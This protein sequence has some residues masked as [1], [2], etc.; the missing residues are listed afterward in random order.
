MTDQELICMLFFF[1]VVIIVVLVL[2]SGIKV[3]KEYERGVI[4]R[5]GKFKGVKGPGIFY[6]FPAFD[7]MQK[8]DLRVVTVDVPP[9]DAITRD[10]ITVKVNAV[11]YY[12]VSSPKIAIIDVEN[13]RLAISQAAQTSV[14]SIIGQYSLVVVIQP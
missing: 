13:Y 10:N 4:F 9:Q 14:R 5:L 8:V 3:L 2:L 1:L 7:S 6:I 12:K 11:L